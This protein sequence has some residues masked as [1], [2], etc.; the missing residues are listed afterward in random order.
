MSELQ[1]RECEHWVTLYSFA[2]ALVVTSL[3]IRITFVTY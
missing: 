1:A 2:Y 3:Q